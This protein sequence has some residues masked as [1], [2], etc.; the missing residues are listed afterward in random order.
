M[1]HLPPKGALFKALKKG[2]K[3][4]LSIPLPVV[5]F[6]EAPQSFWLKINLLMHKDEKSWLQNL[7]NKS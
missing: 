4:R 3:S 7:F 2:I 5:L 1:S 6:S